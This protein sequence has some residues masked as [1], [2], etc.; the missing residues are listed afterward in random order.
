MSFVPYLIN[1]G[2]GSFVFFSPLL[3][4]SLKLGSWHIGL[5]HKYLANLL[6][7]VT[8]KS[9]NTDGVVVTIVVCCV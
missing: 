4:L 7:G 5:T 9:Y 3:F 6:R 8:A 1:T 2:L